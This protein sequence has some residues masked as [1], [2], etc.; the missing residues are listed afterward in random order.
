MHRRLEVALAST[1]LFFE[2]VPPPARAP[3]DV[4]EARLRS[5]G[6]L[7]GSVPR[8][9]AVNVPELVDENHE[10]QPYYRTG[11]PRVFARGL[12]EILGCDAVVNKIVAH[13]DPPR[14]RT[15]AEETARSGLR[16]LVLVGG[17]SRYIPYPGP[18]VAEADEIVGPILAEHDGRLGNVAIPQRTGEGHRM[19]AK[20]R[21]GARFFTTQLVFDPG[22]VLRL[23]REYDQWCRRANVVPATV[24]LSV[25]PLA[26]EA[27]VDFARW[28]GA[29]IPESAERAILAGAESDAVARSIDR[30]LAVW[31][32]V[33]RVV[34]GEAIEVPLGVNVE[35]ISARHLDAA[36]TLLRRLAER[37]GPAASG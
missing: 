37:L 26:D 12:G 33:E 36:G 6:A 20:T 14:L 25:A 11:D 31:E 34:D 9:D 28:F 2:P 16:H 29:E 24:L 27:D 21:A 7:L 35:Q 15:W 5:V 19:L 4:A 23:L 30:A 22:S 1:P 13:L 32:E 10:G 3:P 8:L 17:S 18:S